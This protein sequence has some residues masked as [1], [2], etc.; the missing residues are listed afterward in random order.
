MIIKENTPLSK[1]TTFRI[2]G[3]ARFFAEPKNQ[4][5]LEE[6]LL[7]ASGKGLPSL[8]LGGGS[9]IL[10]ADEGY[11]GL[12]IK[13]G[14]KGIE[15]RERGEEVRVSASA[16]EDWDLFVGMCV[17][18]EFYGIEN[19][20]AIP[21]SVG[22]SPIQNIGAYGVEVKD[23]ISSVEVY[24]KKNKAIK[25][26]TNTDCQFDY[27]DSFFKK[28]DGK[29]FVVTKV[30][31]ILSKKKKLNIEYA[32]VK[33]FF[34]EKEINDPNIK[35]VREAIITIRKN[36]LPDVKLLGTAGSFFKN[37]II[38]KAKLDDLLKKYP[39]L[40]F[41]LV[42]ENKAKIPIAWVI[43]N[44]CCLKGSRVGQVGLYENQAL[45]VVN[46]GTASAK[47]VMEFAH[48]IARK[49]KEKTDLEIFPEVQ[50]IK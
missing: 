37:P 7:F 19:L 21:G 9:N 30:N 16:G 38:S 26:L 2:G 47:E 4:D 48:E 45:V 39:D 6:A 35:D 43:D 23:V 29:N 42:A 25:V 33:K 27:R 8:I 22:A 1:F 44:V 50:I 15:V 28:D 49:V 10:I 34:L 31:F 40:P 5:E 18:K 46:Y 11:P 12:V 3:N 32:D 36:K 17:E 41:H 24:D 20:S 14:I 13:M